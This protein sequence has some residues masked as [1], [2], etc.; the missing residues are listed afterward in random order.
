[1]MEHRTLTDLA[2]L[3]VSGGLAGHD[4]GNGVAAT[5]PGEP[6][7]LVAALEALDAPVLRKL[8]DHVGLEDASELVALRDHRPAEVPGKPQVGRELDRAATSSG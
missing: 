7:D 6:R 2:A 1:M 3:L 8:I 5:A 4:D